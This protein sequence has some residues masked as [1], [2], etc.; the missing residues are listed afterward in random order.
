[1]SSCLQLIAPER[2][3]SRHLHSCPTFE[4]W[5]LYLAIV[6]YIM[7]RKWRSQMNALARTC[8]TTPNGAVD[9]KGELPN[10]LSGKSDV[11]RE[12][13]EAIEPL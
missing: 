7:F 8:K 11:R 10:W 9:V 2:H 12:N 4:A 3:P 6:L 13:D 1:V 5:N